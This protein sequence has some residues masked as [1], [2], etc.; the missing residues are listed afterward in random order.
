MKSLRDV[1]SQTEKQQKHIHVEFKTQIWEYENGRRNQRD[2][3]LKFKLKKRQSLQIFKG[4][5]F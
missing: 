3:K 1:Q 5:I 2:K 4:N